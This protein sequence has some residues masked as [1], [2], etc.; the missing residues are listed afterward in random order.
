MKEDEE[1][2]DLDV[3]LSSIKQ[4]RQDFLGY[5]NDNNIQEKLEEISN[6][7]QPDKFIQRQ[8]GFDADDNE[9][10]GKVLFEKII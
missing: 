10:P 4:M 7:M 1:H 6:I 2:K 9:E 5:M 3:V 8:L